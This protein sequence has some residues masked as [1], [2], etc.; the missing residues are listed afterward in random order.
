M[1]KTTKQNDKEL[2][3]CEECGFHYPRKS[4]RKSARR[5]AGSI[6]AAISR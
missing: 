4:G 6:R 3:Q 5:G 1:V 2:Y